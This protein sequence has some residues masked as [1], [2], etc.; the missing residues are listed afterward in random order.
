MGEIFE[1]TA[2]PVALPWTGE[3]LTTLT[4]GQVEIEHLHRYFFARAL[5]RG[6]DVLDIAAGEGYGSALLAQVARSVTG[7]EI[8]PETVA[9][10][11]EAY[12]KPNLTFLEGDARQI[13]CPDASFDAIVSF[14]TLEHFYEHDHFMTELRRVLRPGG[15]VIMSSPERDVYSPAGSAPNPHHVHELTHDEFAA[16]LHQ[17]FGHVTLYAPAPAA[18]L[19]A[20]G[21]GSAGDAGAAA[22]VRTP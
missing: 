16:L 3:R 10:A 8:A 20:N 7:V 5:C 1:R 2:P 22:H 11:R 18:G 9:H 15:F 19:G 13:P 17:H 6:L 4:S 12:K 14:E 21:R